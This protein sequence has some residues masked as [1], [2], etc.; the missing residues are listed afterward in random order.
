MTI[1]PGVV[2]VLRRYLEGHAEGRYPELVDYL[3]NF[4]KHLRVA[5]SI[6]TL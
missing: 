2:S 4:P 6:T 5:K 1:L 3:P